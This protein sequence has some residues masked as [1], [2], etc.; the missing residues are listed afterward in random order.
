MPAVGTLLCIGILDS[1]ILV[2]FRKYILQAKKEVVPLMKVRSLFLGMS[3]KLTVVLLGDVS[4]NLG[5]SSSNAFGVSTLCSVKD[6]YSYRP[7]AY[8]MKYHLTF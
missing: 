6:T 5:S 3:L 7:R 4:L 2:L 8:I 1:V